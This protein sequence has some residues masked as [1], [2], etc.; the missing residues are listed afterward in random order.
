MG[1]ASLGCSKNLV[2]SENMLGLL[3]EAG[4]E[5]TAEAAE[6][7]A[8]L[9]NTCGFIEAA[10]RESIDTILEMAEHKATGRCRAL[11]VAG[12]LSER[13]REELLRHMPEID[14]MIGIGEVVNIV[15][16]VDRTLRGERLARFSRP[17]RWSTGDPAAR[18]LPR[19]PLTMPHTAYLRIADGC[20]NRC[21]YCAIPAI[22]GALRSR[23]LEELVRE[24]ERLATSGV[25]EVVLVAQDSTA[26]GMDLYGE[27]RLPALIKMISSA[28][29]LRWI[30]L[31]YCYPSR[32]SDE[33]IDV[34]ASEPRVCRYI[35]MPVQHASDRILRGMNRS[36][37][38]A[39]AL[40]AVRNLR[41][42]V[43]GI[44][45]RTT[46]MVGF[47]GEGEG[48]FEELLAFMM[49]ARFD[50]AGVFAYSSEEGT[51]ASAMKPQVPPRVKRE[52]FRRAMELQKGISREINQGL[53]GSKIEI[54]IEG[55]AGRSR[56]VGRTY[57]D[58]PG[59]DGVVRV[60]GEGLAPGCFV[61]GL[62]TRVSA[63]DLWA[64]LA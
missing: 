57:R 36:H 63:Y 59:V 26:Y 38:S 34:M 16:V 29:G 52:R 32:I 31:M 4:Y 18:P 49:A 53:I 58:A 2:D 3:A 13:Y 28:G 44:A 39:A 55:R 25:R 17:P 14:S 41:A 5:I 47:P 7:D 30:R 48:D 62:V 27:A 19:F 10:K 9:I 24:S 20:S 42:A 8:L 15:D 46:F 54:L 56:W 6:A 21:S 51:P 35:D 1:M 23:P 12:C 50:R 60:R 43:P 33:L 61:T 40:R 45:I 37:D 11:I 22:R 64:T